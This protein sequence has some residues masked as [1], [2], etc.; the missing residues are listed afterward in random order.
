METRLA[1]LRGINVGGNKKIPMAELRALVDGLGWQHVTTYIASGNV[2]YASAATTV[3]D[4]AALEAATA[5]H[6]GFGVDVIVRPAERWYELAA[7][8]PFADAER[9]RAKF[10][11]LGMSKA[12]P[13]DDAADRLA[14]YVAEEESVALIEDG[15]WLDFANGAGRTRLT[16]AVLDRC[17]G[18][19]VTARN[20]RTVQKL[21]ELLREVG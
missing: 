18:S 15:I 21:A 9:D 11:H 6:F 8:G 13:L 20:W 4:E 17:L 5:S 2:V 7:G 16:P 14:K 19:T 1:L 12:P 3:E 10:L